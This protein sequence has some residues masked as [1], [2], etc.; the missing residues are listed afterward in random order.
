MLASFCSLVLGPHPT[1]CLPP[2]EHLVVDVWVLSFPLPNCTLLSL[3]IFNHLSVGNYTQYC[4]CLEAILSLCV[5]GCLWLIYILKGLEGRGV[6]V[7]Q[8]SNLQVKCVCCQTLISGGYTWF[9]QT[10]YVFMSCSVCRVRDDSS[11]ASPFFLVCFNVSLQSKDLL[12]TVNAHY[13]H[14]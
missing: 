5:W 11:C 2:F 6:L 7:S 13:H 4:G 8:V 14:S 10:M 1:N 3:S 9:E 12:S